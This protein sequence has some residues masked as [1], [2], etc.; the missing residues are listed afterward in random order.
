MS[1]AI[2]NAIPP[3]AGGVI[4]RLAVA[5]LIANGVDPTPILRESHLSID[6]IADPH[7]R[8]AASSQIAVLNIAADVLRDDVLGFRLA[9]NFDGARRREAA[10]FYFVLASSTTLGEALTRAE[11]YSRVGN[12]GLIVQY[13]SK[14]ECCIRYKYDG[15]ARHTDRHQIEF[16]VTAFARL[17]QRLTDND[18]RPVRISFAHPRCSASAELDHFFGC[19]IAFGADRDELAFARRT[20]ELPVK[21]AN[22]YLNELLVRHCD[23]ALAQRT[24]CTTSTRTGVESTIAPLLPHGRARADEVARQLGMSRRTFSRRLSA[25]GITF[26]T[27]LEEMRK[28]LALHYLK[29]ASLSVSEIGW[30]LGFQGTS[31]FTNAFKRWTG[32]TPRQMRMQ[33]ARENNGFSDEHARMRA[34]S[35]SPT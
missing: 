13:F 29:D 21:D 19:E 22:P 26:I 4:A 33:C 8:I 31:A 30:L 17:C 6:Q 25:E 7:A 28:D 10:L 14:D 20:S 1:P 32:L 2:G 35:H 12:E 15:V 18:V 24:R 5:R 23:E 9:Q 27:I 34:S 16:W 3:T 11:R